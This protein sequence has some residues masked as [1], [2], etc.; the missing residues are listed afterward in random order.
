VKKTSRNV[1]VFCLLL[2]SLTITSILLLVLSPAPLTPDA[3]VSLFAVDQPVS[4]DALYKTTQPI[5][6]GR[7][8]YI[9]IHHSQTASGNALLLGQ[10]T[11]GVG[12]HFV[13]GNGQGCGDGE[14][15]ISRRWNRQQSAQPAGAKVNDS[16]ISIC[17][18]G[19][20]DQTTPTSLQ[21]QR[22]SQLV[23]SLQT[24]FSIPAS[25]VLLVNQENT[26]AGMG[27]LFPLDQFRKQL[28]P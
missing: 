5:G 27:R 15:Q 6:D 4:L 3:V 14:I 28:V 1:V 18:I 17:L 22:I 23:Q 9:F 26:P 16:C 20:L 11:D 10:T 21:Q 25:K 7:W 19:N 12:D 2:S 13:I 24:R 8:S